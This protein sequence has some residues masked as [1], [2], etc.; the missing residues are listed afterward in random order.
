MRRTETARI[1]MIVVILIAAFYFLLPTIRL[2]TTSDED[3]ARLKRT[4]KLSY[5]NLI[6]NSIK[7]GLDLQGGLR[8]VLEPEVDDIKSQ[9]GSNFADQ[10]LVIISNRINGMGLTEP[11]IR[12]R[13]NNQIVVEIPGI[14]S[15]SVADAKDQISQIAKL[16]FR[17]LETPAVTEQTIQSIDSYLASKYG[18]EYDITPDSAEV[19][20]VETDSAIETPVEAET[21]DTQA[22]D[23]SATA[24]AD[25]SEDV[26]PEKEEGETAFAET[27]LSV[28]LMSADRSSFYIKSNIDRVRKILS[29]PEVQEWIPEKSEFLFSTGPEDF[30]GIFYNRLYLVKKEIVLTG[31]TI[32]NISPATDQFNKPEVD[33]SI[34]SNDRSKWASVT[35][36]NLQKPLAIVLDN[37][38]ESAPNIQDQI[39]NAGRITMRS[40]ATFV[41]AQ[42]LANVLKSG[43]LPTRLL[44]KEDV[45]IGPSLGKDSIR[46][47]ITASI[48]GLLIVVAFLLFYYRV[49]GIVAAIALLFNIFVLM[50]VLVVFNATLTVPG[51]AG[52]VLLVGISVDAA[53][54]IF[55][56][57]REELRAGK[58]VRAAIDAGYG[59]AAVAIIDS[60]ITILIVASLLYYIGS[61]PVKGF[62]ITL[63][64][65]I[66]ISLFS[67]LVVTRTIFEFRKTYKKLS[68]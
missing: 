27:S 3:I 22:I 35:G 9:A 34:K 4:D 42:K 62:A 45:I 40:G 68:I 18:D 51:V 65:G 32:E 19:E 52:I 54:L 36:N 66:L 47:G 8:L 13:K 29:L 12:K 61:G 38:V 63:V 25:V 16:E 37:R 23:D 57:I 26:T 67:A 1:V 24:V 44:I 64:L 7:L 41:D 10:A 60:N 58:P 28:Y 6:R 14:D 30:N 31:E 55:E 43:S 39:I 59:R 48:V 56:R 5:D 21:P 53:V 17:F 50:A 49:S 20:P 33:F 2:M 15:I 11:E 46:K